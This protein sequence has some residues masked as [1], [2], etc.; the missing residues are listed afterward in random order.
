M[1]A[2][3]I[4]EHRA[5]DKKVIPTCIKTIRSTIGPIRAS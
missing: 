1:V 5:A 3:G 4:E 2:E